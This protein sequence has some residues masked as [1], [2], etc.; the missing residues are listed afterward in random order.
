[1][2]DMRMPFERLME[3]VA[4]LG[5]DDGLTLGA[6]AERWGETRARTG[7]AIDAVRV[8]NGERTYIG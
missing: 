4:A 7:D 5:P 6:L 3:L 2:P 8:V 1:M